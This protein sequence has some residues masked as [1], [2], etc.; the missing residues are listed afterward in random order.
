MQQCIIMD[1]NQDDPASTMVACFHIS[2]CYIGAAIQPCRLT[3]QSLLC[4]Y[5]STVAVMLSEMQQL[6]I[7]EAPM[8]VRN[9]WLI[10]S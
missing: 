5:P 1:K 4:K 8:S 10:D 6:V 2:K 9:T 3:P 7:H